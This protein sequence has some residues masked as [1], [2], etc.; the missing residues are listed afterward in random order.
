MCGEPGGRLGE[1]ASR[2]HGGSLGRN[3]EGMITVGGMTPNNTA[4]L[5]TCRGGVEVLAPAQGIFSASIT[6]ADHYR[7]RKPNQRNGTSFA[8]PIIAGIAARLLS[9]RPDLSPAQIEAWITATPSRECAMRMAFCS[10][11]VLQAFGM[12]HGS[13]RS[14]TF[15]P[16][17]SST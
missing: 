7:G 15:A 1:H 10:S 11:G 14:T 2:F 6:A 13:S 5:G 8:A 16:H 17:P 3:V 12:T 9:D 4:W